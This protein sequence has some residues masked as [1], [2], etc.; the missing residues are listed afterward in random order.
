M[1]WSL[2]KYRWL[3]NFNVCST[4]QDKFCREGLKKLVM[5]TDQETEFSSSGK[6]TFWNFFPFQIITENWN[7]SWDEK[8]L[9]DQHCF[10]L[11][12]WNKTFHSDPFNQKIENFSPAEFWQKPH[13]HIGKILVQN[14]SASSTCNIWSMQWAH[15]EALGKGSLFCRGEMSFRNDFPFPKATCHWLSLYLTEALSTTLNVIH[16]NNSKCTLFLWN[17][18]LQGSRRCS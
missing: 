5:T 11:T 18:P 16:R 7:I 3:D 2:L 9:N 4:Y 17:E 12:L 6:P 13:L 14:I 1:P 15:A 10:K 8:V